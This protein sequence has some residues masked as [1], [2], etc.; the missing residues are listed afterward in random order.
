MKR[1]RDF[2]DSLDDLCAKCARLCKEVRALPLS[3]LRLALRLPPAS[4]DAQPFPFLELPPELQRMIAIDH[5]DVATLHSLFQTCR[6]YASHA[7]VP[8][9]EGSR[10]PPFCYA[11][12][13]SPAHDIGRAVAENGYR[14]LL[15]WWAPPLVQEYDEYHGMSFSTI[16]ILPNYLYNPLLA[17]TH[18]HSEMAYAMAFDYQLANPN[19]GLRR[20]IYELFVLATGKPWFALDEHGAPIIPACRE[21]HGMSASSFETPVMAA[22]FHANRKDIRYDYRHDNK[23]WCALSLER[24]VYLTISVD[25]WRPSITTGSTFQAPVYSLAPNGFCDMVCGILLRPDAQ[26]VLRA[27]YLIA[28]MQPEAQV[29]NDPRLLVA[30]RQTEVPAGMSK[31]VAYALATGNASALSYIFPDRILVRILTNS[32]RTEPRPRPM[33]RHTLHDRFGPYLMADA[34]GN[35]RTWLNLDANVDAKDALENATQHVGAGP[36]GGRDSADLL[37]D[38]DFYDYWRLSIARGRPIPPA[39]LGYA[40][41]ED[42]YDEYSIDSPFQ[43]MEHGVA[44]HLERFNRM[45]YTWGQPGSSVRWRDVTRLVD[46]LLTI[47][48]QANHGTAKYSDER[49]RM[50]RHPNGV[51]IF[52]SIDT[53][54]SHGVC[55]RAQR[56]RLARLLPHGIVASYYVDYLD[57]RESTV[58]GPDS[59]LVAVLCRG[60][61]PLPRSVNELASLAKA[62]GYEI[63]PPGVFCPVL[64]RAAL[65]ECAW[66]KKCVPLRELRDELAHLVDLGGNDDFPAEY[67]A[68][69]LEAHGIHVEQDV[70][71]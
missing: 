17:L 21:F 53:L 61:A 41:R 39:S 13:G 7:Q 30:H 38:Y 54:L 8:P 69:I 19:S 4:H 34:S 51:D 58:P 48:E 63:Q 33:Q 14:D 11:K 1:Q 29:L 46:K 23:D 25:K 45:L 40:I 15:E 42:P 9:E 67:A 49:Y 27:L 32:M 36:R 50:W 57:R 24:T 52:Y 71:A 18:G 6:A 65:D 2:D 70:Q 66:A 62:Y 44:Q 64:R 56:Q 20:G 12:D 35:S 43:V 37:I 5:C 55:S 28:H 59:F 16:A 10:E 22:A 31:I 47:I 26:D 60:D 68:A 3:S